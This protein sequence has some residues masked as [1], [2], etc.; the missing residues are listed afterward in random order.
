MADTTGKPATD[1]VVVRFLD[2]DGTFPN[3]AVLPLVIYRD[4]LT[5]PPDDPASG[6]EE[7]FQEHGWR[8]G[9]WRNGIFHYH[10]YHSNTH[11]VLGVYSGEARVQLGGDNGLVTTVGVGDVIM[12]PAG[13]CHKNL[14]E[15]PDFTVVGAYPDGYS[16]D[17]CR[18]A[19]GERPRVD[20]AIRQVGLPAADPVYG[21]AGPLLRHWAG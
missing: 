11:E 8:G 3:N 1:R 13:V 12:I 5:L 14:G 15:S 10:H 4:A 21:V 9:G 16:P 19:T 2:D 6:F 17:L 18:G 7:A 20:R